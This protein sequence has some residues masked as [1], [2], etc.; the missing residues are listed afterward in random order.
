M[1]LSR[2]GYVVICTIVA[3]CVSLRAEEALKAQAM[4]IGVADGLVTM[5]VEY[6]P[7]SDVVRSFSRLTG[8]NIVVDDRQLMGRTVTVS[9]RD[10]PWEPA[11]RSILDSVNM[12]LEERGD[13]I[14]FIVPVSIEDEDSEVSDLHIEQM[15]TGQFVSNYLSVIIQEISKPE[16]AEALATFDKNY[17]DALIRKGFTEDQAF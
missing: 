3:G 5:Q 7:L 15:L 11:L 14:Y 6:A 13:G 12:K 8:E 16:Y 4:E 1:R 2:I 17:Y 9:M 10:V